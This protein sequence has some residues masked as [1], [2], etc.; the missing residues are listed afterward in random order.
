MSETTA[1]APSAER[2]SPLQTA[3]DVSNAATVKG[4]VAVAVGLTI[5]VVPGVTI[6]VA[7]YAIGFGLLTVGLYDI[8]YGL[9]GRTRNRR[10][11]RPVSLIRG[12]T[13]LAA[14]LVGGLGFAPSANIGH[15]VSIFEAVHG[16]APDIAGKDLANPTSLLLSGLMMLRH[17]GLMK[18]ANTIENALIYTL[19]QGIHT[20]DFGEG[21]GK[22]S[23]GTTAF[24]K[25]IKDHLG[26][27][28]QSREPL[29]TEGVNDSVN[30]KRPE[31]P[32][33][34]KLMR[35]FETLKSVYVGCDIYLDT[36]ASPQ[37]LADRL[38]DICGTTPFELKMM[39]NR[40]TQVWPSGSI[41]TEIVDY[42]R[43][44]FELRDLSRAPSLGQG[45]IIRLLDRIAEK[46]EVTD[47]QPL[48]F[49]DGKPGYS[50]A[51]GQ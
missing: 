6:T 23:V 50:L 44:R 48:K 41:Y 9:S 21:S 11:T 47:F 37:E 33:H 31:R 22:P 19:E 8:W 10:R 17:I 35:T 1:P 32:R 42:Y 18:H 43:V 28:P 34:N 25:A 3:R 40:G 13:S 2:R 26:N 7:G 36:L 24:G 45:P 29:K 51:Q 20:G 27:T 4:A 5:V 12:L 49:F 16:T 39:S 38:K 46:F 14:G 15:H 30:V